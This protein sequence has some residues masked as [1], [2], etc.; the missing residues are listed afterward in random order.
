MSNETKKYAGLE[1]LRAFLDGCRT[2]FASITHKH[3]ISDITDY[4]VDSELSSESA[5]PVQNKTINAEF[6][7]L[8]DAMSDLRVAINEKIDSAT[9]SETYETKADAQLKYDEITSHNHSWDDI[10]DKPFDYAPVSEIYTYDGNPEGKE[11]ND[12]AVK[13]SSDIP[14]SLLY[15]KIDGYKLMIY[16]D[17]EITES[18]CILLEQDTVDDGKIYSIMASDDGELSA[19]PLG[20]IAMSGDNKGLYLADYRELGWQ[21]Y[22][23]SL[24]CPTVEIETIRENVLPDTLA[25]K[26]YVHENFA[27]KSD[28][29]DVDLSAYE[30]KEDA[31]L[32]YDEITGSKADWNQNNENAIDYI[33]N[34]THGEILAES[35]VIIFDNKTVDFIKEPMMPNVSSSIL[36]F[37]NSDL[38]VGQIYTVVWDGTTYENLV[39]FEDDN[40]G[41]KSLGSAENMLGETGVYPFF[42]QNIDDTELLFVT[43]DTNIFKHTVQ[44]STISKVITVKQ[45]DE[46]YIPDTIARKEYVDSTFARKSDVQDVDL[47]N[48]YTKE[49]IDNL[50]LITVDDIDTICGASIQI[51]SAKGVVF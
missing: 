20:A 12:G 26:D 2:L 10:E 11:I 23:I 8:A 34:K 1:S 15:G 18:N 47:S 6:D 43:S 17:G 36:E 7:A 33:K 51:A 28:I 27:L 16:V 38:V 24:T 50:E 21:L 44:V 14:L 39:C 41:Y 40:E 19:L 46:K 4:T 31:Q 49:E 48:Y 9:V 35:E 45:L 42:I 13:V 3:T 32:K 37:S 25:R 22:V 29:K 5:N 30:T